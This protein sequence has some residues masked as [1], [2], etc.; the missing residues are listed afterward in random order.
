MSRPIPMTPPADRASLAVERL[1]C[2]D[3][4]TTAAPMTRNEM[5]E[6][7]STSLSDLSADVLASARPDRVICTLFGAGLDAYAVIERLECLG[8]AGQ[9]T[10]LAPPLPR[11]KLVEAELRA[12]GPGRRLTLLPLG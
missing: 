9:I 11:P 7:L 6:V 12:Q 5:G 1:L 10:V 3:I 8:Y 2:V 4:S